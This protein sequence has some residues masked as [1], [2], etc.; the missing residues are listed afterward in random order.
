MFKCSMKSFE[1]AP[2]KAAF[3]ENYVFMLSLSLFFVNVEQL[4]TAN[5]SHY[6]HLYVFTFQVRRIWLQNQ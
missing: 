5:Y 6:S 4:C 2:N 3:Q 1:K